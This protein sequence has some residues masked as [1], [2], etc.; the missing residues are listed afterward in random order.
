MSRG[1]LI[2]ELLE[3]FWKEHKSSINLAKM[4]EKVTQKKY[5]NFNS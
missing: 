4:S 3:K 1:N 5:R 2:H